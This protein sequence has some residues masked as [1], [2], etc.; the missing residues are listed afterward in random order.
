MYNDLV[1]ILTP[2]SSLLKVTW[3]VF[4]HIQNDECCWHLCSQIISSV[5][6]I[7]NE[8]EAEM[9]FWSISFS[10]R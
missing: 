10:A 5:V 3:L 2:L 8:P 1:Y 6:I 7:L 4:F 9:P